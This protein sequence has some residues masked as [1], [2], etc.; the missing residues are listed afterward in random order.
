MD[1]ATR[2]ALDAVPELAAVY[3]LTRRGWRWVSLTRGPG[4]L[5][6]SFA[7]PG[8]GFVDWCVIRGHG[9]VEGVRVRDG[10]WVVWRLSGSVGGR[11]RAGS[12]ATTEFLVR[13]PA[14]DRSSLAAPGATPPPLTPAV[15]A[16]G[17]AGPAT[18]PAAV[19]R[20]A[21]PPESVP[22][23]LRSRRPHRH[24]LPAAG[25]GHH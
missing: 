10:D 19:R 22:C 11:R 21:P 17:L 6:G 9:E 2:K 4:A 25:G 1:A 16:V 24:G 13:A 7:W 15:P 18:R 12:L 14:A 23:G 3:A 20:T 8:G 5:V